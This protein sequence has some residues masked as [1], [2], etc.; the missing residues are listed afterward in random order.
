MRS[1]T[2]KIPHL[3]YEKT[4]LKPPMECVILFTIDDLFTKDV[5]WWG[6]E[7]NPEIYQNEYEIPRKNSPF[8]C[9]LVPHVYKME[10][11]RFPMSEN[12]EN[13]PDLPSMREGS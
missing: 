8:G 7:K 6:W 1:A 5:I 13:K 9:P 12:T 4:Y 11:G 2:T 10:A 3:L